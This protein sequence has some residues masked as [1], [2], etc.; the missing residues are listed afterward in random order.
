M[1]SL[2][3]EI[4]EKVKSNKHEVNFANS[5]GEDD[6]CYVEHQNY[7][8]TKKT[9]EESRIDPKKQNKEH[10]QDQINYDNKHNKKVLGVYST[11]INLEHISRKERPKRSKTIT[12]KN[13]K[14]NHLNKFFYADKSQAYSKTIKN[15]VDS[16]DWKFDS[17]KSNNKHANT[18]ANNQFTTGVSSIE[19]INNKIILDTKSNIFHNVQNNENDL[20]LNNSCCSKRKNNKHTKQEHNQTEQSSLE[21][22]FNELIAKLD[23]K[24]FKETEYSGSASCYSDYNNMNEGSSLKNKTLNKKTSN[25]INAASKMSSKASSNNQKNLAKKSTKTDPINQLKFSN[26]TIALSQ[27][28]DFIVRSELKSNEKEVGEQV[29]ESKQQQNA[30]SNEKSDN[31][32]QKL[33]T[34]VEQVSSS[35]NENKQQQHRRSSKVLSKVKQGIIKEESTNNNSNFKEKIIFKNENAN[36]DDDDSDSHNNSSTG[37]GSNKRKYQYQSNSQGK[38]ISSGEDTENRK[39]NN[40]LERNCN[41][42]NTETEDFSNTCFESHQ[43]QNNDTNTQSNNILTNKEKNLLQNNKRTSE[44][45]IQIRSRKGLIRTLQ[46][47]IGDK[48]SNNIKNQV[49]SIVESMQGSKFLQKILPTLSSQVVNLLFHEVS[50]FILILNN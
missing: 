3:L 26:L 31:S 48:R 1:N 27:Q 7:K 14:K 9:P 37:S 19:K 4:S 17:W 24:E 36:E 5:E 45:V 42:M 22:E 49:L 2:D 32:K 29:F 40:D 8:K 20:L 38:K 30:N 10:K 21:G 46:N 28:F 11:N 6:L 43:K 50:F 23:V 41:K 15:H 33:E 35:A 12:K 18:K 44:I 34:I 39:S 47:F 16:V 25:S 13:N